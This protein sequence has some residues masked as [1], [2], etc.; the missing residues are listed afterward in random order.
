MEALMIRDRHHPSIVLW[1]VRV[2][3]SPDC[4]PLY[5][6][7][8]ELAKR[9]DSARQT[10]GI[11]S[12]ANVGAIAE[13]VYA[14]N[15]YT[16]TGDNAP[17]EKRKTGSK[18]KVP[19]LVTGHTGYRFPVRAYD[20]E[21]Q[22]TE[23]ALRHARVL[24]AAY[25]DKELCGVI[26]C[27]FADY[28]SNSR[29]GGADNVC[30]YGVTD[31]ARVKKLAAYVYESQC[32]DHPVMELSSSLCGGDNPNRALGK[33]YVFTNCDFVRLTRNGKVVGEFVPDI[34]NYPNLPHPP[35]V[36]DDFIG[37]LLVTEEGI[38]AK[39]A[40]IIKNALT[41]MAKDG[42]HPSDAR[43]RSAAAMA[44]YK[45]N[46]EQVCALYDKYFARRFGGARLQF[47]GIKN[48]EVVRSIVSE[49]VYETGL[50]VECDR[51]ELVSDETYDCARIELTAVD[52][53]GNRLFGCFDAVT[54]ECEGSI[55]VIGSKLFS[56]CGG[57]AAFFVKTKGG[58]GTA[59]VRIT[60]ESLG[61][62]TVE[63]EIRRIL[64]A[65]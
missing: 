39:D 28:N 2:E 45:L 14:Y 65:K 10:A 32:D 48:G 20:S 42:E 12:S 63:L 1:G 59:K 44:R 30:A 13:D 64:P 54:V 58:K 31:A 36:I 8:N 11:R 41:L 51:T 27:S 7:T 52:Q 26:G 6:K 24:D 3:E 61:N 49:P 43:V 33:V 23:Q 25:G 55:E 50:R 34:T 18:N 29:N 57:A 9:L 19:Y 35:V 38:D 4:E 15:D 62:H 40:A 47:D 53:N 60:T 37:N 17:L 21:A 16:F 5:T 56:L 46:P 22:R